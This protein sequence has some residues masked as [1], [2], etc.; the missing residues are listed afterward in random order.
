MLFITGCNR[1]LILPSDKPYIS[2]V[3]PDKT[4]GVSGNTISIAISVQNPTQID[5]TGNL[6][7]QADSPDCFGM[8][9]VT[10]GTANYVRGN[11]APISVPA[12]K[13]NSGLITI[14]IPQ[15]NQQSCYN[16]SNHKLTIYIL[17]NDKILDTKYLDFNLFQHQ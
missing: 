13:S 4:F 14:N 5:Y 16:I 10:V 1:P 11:I 12:G 9:T 15:N 17:Q 6:L 2:N 8:D 3:N 7:V